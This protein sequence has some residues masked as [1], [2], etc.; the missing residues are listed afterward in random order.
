MQ[1]SLYYLNTREEMMD[2]LPRTA[3][4]NVLEV[5]CGEGVFGHN[6]KNVSNCK[7]TGIEINNKAAMNAKEKLDRVIHGDFCELNVS[8]LDTNYDLVVMNDVL[9][10]FAYPEN[11][12]KKINS[13]QEKGDS[14]ICS[15]PNVRY[16]RHL[17]EVIFLKDWRYRS[18]G[19]LDN[20]HLKFF[21]KKS[22]IRLFE[23]NG[24]EVVKIK[25]L[26]PLNKFKFFFL[27]LLL[28]FRHSD[29]KYLQYGLHVRKI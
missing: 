28:L 26:R 14:I 18:E 17:L 11:I 4:K 22:I 13:L 1:D 20:T 6:L 16:A 8:D 29:M 21:T 27:D 23:E 2:F 10:H 7:V 3:L 15:V 9:E 25:G 12:L 24:Y 19:I 5:G